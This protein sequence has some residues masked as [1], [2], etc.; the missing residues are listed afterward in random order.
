MIRVLH[1][2][3]RFSP[4]FTGDGLYYLR[5]I[6][7]MAQQGTQHRVLATET[8]GPAE[9]ADINGCRVDYLATHRLG[10]KALAL[11][12]WLLA[13]ANEFDVLHI[14]SHVDW[15][16]S[17]YVMAR[18][19]GKRVLFSCT[20]DDSVPEILATYRPWWRPLAL[21]L[22]GAI[23]CFVAISPR[24]Y[25]ACTQAV[26]PERVRYIPQGIE[27]RCGP[28]PWPQQ[29]RQVREALGIADHEL[30]LLCVASIAERKNQE[31][32]VEVLARLREPR[33]RLVLVGPVLEPAY[34]ETLHALI[35]RHGLRSQVIEVGFESDPSRYYQAAD[36]F[37]F[38]SKAEGFC[39]VYLEAMCHS[40]PV[41]TR[42]LP[43]LSD[44]VFD[45]GRTGALAQTVEQFVDVLRPL[46]DDPAARQRIGQA[47][48]VE[49]LRHY[50]LDRVAQ[51]YVALYRDD[52]V[53][54]AGAA[55]SSTTAIVNPVTACSQW[56][57]GPALVG[58]RPLPP[59]ER[60]QLLIVVDTEAEFDWSKGTAD[61]SGRVQAISALAPFV[62]RLL[63]EQAPPCL[64][65]D[66]PV[67]TGSESAPVLQALGARGAE[68]GVH[69][70]PWSTP[71]F[72]EPLDNWH[73]YCGNLSPQFE[74]AKLRVLKTAVEKIASAPV[75]SFK[76]GRYGAG[77][78]TLA[79][80]PLQGLD[81]DLSICP[82]YDLG[83][84]GGPDW[85]GFD[86][87]PAWIGAGHRLI[88][89]PTTAG[90]SGPVS[91]TLNRHAPGLR[92]QKAL[93][94]LH[95]GR[96]HRL[97]PEGNSLGDLLALTQALMRDGQRVFTLS[98]HSPSLAA[99]CTPYA[100]TPAE[101]AQMGDSILRYIDTFRS[102]W[103]GDVQLPSSLAD[104]Y[105]A[106]A[107]A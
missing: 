49:M 71:P 48:R 56:R 63:A 41:V 37:V 35:E 96:L 23:H 42:Y 95:L 31:F 26:P 3:R 74:A 59:T 46:L 39:N 106:R 64:V 76:A 98:F 24:L 17:A 20:L 25:L 61:D 90:Y 92:L 52:P 11:H 77:P 65:L 51:A 9:G 85:T 30:M 91:G 4:D 103:G 29:R 36:A 72:G 38:A 28:G 27:D 16:L 8:L 21:R 5:L 99:G 89:L 80:L 34:A 13:H 58:L 102:R 19:L 12:R 105:R 47:A 101:V 43:G 44:Y 1:L 45:P 66:H 87:R 70:Q 68:L 67:A 81:I 60:P 83:R 54:P 32:L 15:R 75:R 50:T 97:T 2:Y 22:M 10:G 88:S 104:A 55:Q 100:R 62:E 94:R 82:G 53:L 14:H 40:L 33:A 7:L 78:A 18:L 93:A 6:P 69:L 73:S 86:S 79:Q 107:D 84:D 57:A